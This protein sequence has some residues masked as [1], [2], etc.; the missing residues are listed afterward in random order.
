MLHV[1]RATG[2]FDITKKTNI[3]KICNVT[4]GKEGY[5]HPYQFDMEALAAVPL[6]T[7]LCHVS[8]NRLMSVRAL[9]TVCS[10]LVTRIT[11][12]AK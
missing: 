7:C 6:E 4:F 11:P 9:S 8:C 3:E 1:Q 2:G 10:P 5:K 12:L